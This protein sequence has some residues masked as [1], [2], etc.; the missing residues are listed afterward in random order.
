MPGR[1]GQQCLHRWQKSINPTIRRA[2]WTAEEDARL[3][4]AVSLYG[5]SW[6][7]VRFHVPGRTDVQ[8]RERWM[9]ILN[10]D[11]HRAPWTAAVQDGEPRTAC[12]AIPRGPPCRG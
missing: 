7:R 12:R 4:T 3:T 6:A 8:C 11:L 9:N 1:T 5:H 10:P 2:R